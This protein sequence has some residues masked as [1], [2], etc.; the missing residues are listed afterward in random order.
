[1]LQLRLTNYTTK[2]F[3]PTSLLNFIRNQNVVVAENYKQFSADAAT[4]SDRG[5]D[6][7]DDIEILHKL[8][9]TFINETAAG[10]VVPIYKKALLHGNKIAIKDATAEYSYAQLYNGAKKLSTQI[11]N[12]C[13]N[14]NWFLIILFLTNKT[15]MTRP[16]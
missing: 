1:M 2:K 9:Q 14:Y 15:S 5:C 7:K 16:C 3:S 10:G 13:G 6:Q 8:K 12:L 4:K 11:S